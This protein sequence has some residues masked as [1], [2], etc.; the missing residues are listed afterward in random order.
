MTNPIPPLHKSITVPWAPDAAFRRF[1]E[2]IDAWW[3]LR[4]HSVGGEKADL[5]VFEGKVGGRIYE[6][7][8]DGAEHTWGTVTGWEPPTRVAFTWHPGME[9]ETSQQIE[10]RFLAA[11]QGTRLELT[12]TGWERLGE[13]ARKA[14]KGYPIGWSYVL[15][16]YADRKSSPLVFAL[17][18]VMWILRGVQRRG[19]KS[20]ASS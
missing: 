11:A 1:T 14:R 19:V 16:L 10:V 4:S 6:R 17:D 3:P 8:R 9:S 12:H 13:L 5:V 15:L 20:A 18:G 2:Q 7:N